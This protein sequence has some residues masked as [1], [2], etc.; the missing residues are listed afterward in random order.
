MVRNKHN[1]IKIQCYLKQIKIVKIYFFFDFS[2]MHTIVFI[3]WNPSV[4]HDKN[5]E[6]W[7]QT[8]AHLVHQ[9]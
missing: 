3:T 7:K 5:G 4:K 6:N 9:C 8:V 1:T 2:N